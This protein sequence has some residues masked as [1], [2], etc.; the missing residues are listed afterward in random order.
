M[1]LRANR[2]GRCYEL[3][4]NKV[5]ELHR[6]ANDA[7]LVHGVIK[8]TNLKLSDTVGV[9][10]HAW[11]ESEGMVW[12][13]VTKLIAPIDVFNHLFDAET[14]HRYGRKIALKLALESGHCGPWRD[15]PDH[16]QV[17]IPK[18]TVDG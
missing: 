10:C 14:I 11:V 15:M 16:L 3:A 17:T 9:I 13:P 12:E 4:F 1:T 7:V 18:E 5:V 2:A 8:S 6:M